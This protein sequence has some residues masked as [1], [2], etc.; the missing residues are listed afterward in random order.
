M[1]D[2]NLSCVRMEDTDFVMVPGIPNLNHQER[3]TVVNNAEVIAI[4]FGWDSHYGW[5]SWPVKAQHVAIGAEYV[6]DIIDHNCL[7]PASWQR[8]RVQD[9][10]G[11]GS[12][13]EA[14]ESGGFPLV[15]VVLTT[16]HVDGVSQSRCRH[17]SNRS[18]QISN[19]DPGIVPGSIA[20]NAA[21]RVISQKTADWVQAIP[22][23][24]QGV[25]GPTFM[26]GAALIPAIAFGV[27]ADQTVLKDV[28]DSTRHK[29]VT[30][31]DTGCFAVSKVGELGQSEEL[32]ALKAKADN[33]L[34][35][36]IHHHQNILTAI[37]EY[38]NRFPSL[39]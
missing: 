19:L 2:M 26:H 4:Q 16:K 21:D 24:H 33:L 7:A 35:S 8:K 13:I 30:H 12:G 9:A 15:S 10:A 20:L 6:D 11:F 39:L 32:L 34:P 22:H 27:K 17:S 1:H 25:V 28:T 14:L 31:V 23:G 18:S 29:D 3:S 38:I 36:A 37:P 5:G